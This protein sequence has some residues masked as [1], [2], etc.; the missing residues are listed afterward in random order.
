MQQTQQLTNG[1]LLQRR[2]RMIRDHDRHAG[3]ELPV[4]HAGQRV[5]ILNKETRLWSPGEIVSLSGQ[6]HVRTLLKPQT[7]QYY[8]EPEL[9]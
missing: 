7:G 4:L 1:Q 6:S 8:A 9:T 5:T 3:P 2:D